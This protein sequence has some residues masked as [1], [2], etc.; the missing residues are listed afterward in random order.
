MSMIK[1]AYSPNVVTDSFYDVDAMKL[2]PESEDAIKASLQFKNT[3]TAAKKTIKR[4]SD[5]MYVR[6]RAIGSLEKWGPNL[7]GDGFPLKELQASYMTF[8]GKG[9]FIDHKSD[10]ITKIRGLVI[11]AYMNNEDQAIETLIAVDKVS[12]PQL[13]RDIHTGV[14]NSV[15]M[16][17]RVGYSYCSVCNNMARTEKD[18]CQHIANY[19][20]MKI[21]MFT[22]NDRHKFGKY[23]V[24]EVN[25]QLEFIELSWVSVP[26][27]KEA[28]VLEKIA[29]LKDGVNNNFNT[30]LTD[31][32]KE[33]LS[34]AQKRS[35]SFAI[36]Q[37]L[38]D[39]ES[40]A[41]CNGEECE[42]DPRITS[43]NKD[44]NM[45]KTA[46]E[47]KRI[48]IRQDEITVRK[49][50]HDYKAIGQV[51]NENK[52]NPWWAFSTDKV[53]WNVNLDENICS[54]VSAAGQKQ[55]IDAIEQMLTK[56]I[57]S[58]ELI[59]A[60]VNG[61][62]TKVS[63]LQSGEKDPLID[64]DLKDKVLNNKRIYEANDDPRMQEYETYK[65]TAS[66]GPSGDLGKPLSEKDETL[67]SEELKRKKDLH[68]A[69]LEFLFNKRS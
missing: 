49:T 35:V 14:V 15:S 22:N 38:K 28:N 18:Y 30:D 32:E 44:K 29:S 9:N 64:G 65:Q 21:G 42:F 13:A 2:N 63:Y 17:T 10:D 5:F 4:S 68:R 11:D 69:A 37:S 46:G 62:L 3:V 55:I 59:V 57:D 67:N 39:I 33:I 20:G 41:K 36:P 45:E 66:E 48:T 34:F 53:K 7:N 61:M 50:S 23:A 8:A 1:I 43:T 56:N 6:T 19:K 12:H 52:S 26:A 47:M 31:S 54:Q 16:G 40:A 51:T 25:H 58:T 27:F 24:H 60:S